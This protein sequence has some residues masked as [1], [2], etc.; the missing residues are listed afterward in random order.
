MEQEKPI[1]MFDQPAK[2]DSAGKIWQAARLA[3]EG[4]LFMVGRGE[5]IRWGTY[6]G[7]ELKETKEA[8]YQI[9][10]LEECEAP[11]LKPIDD[12]LYNDEYRLIEKANRCYGHDR[13]RFIGDEK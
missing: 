10:I 8:I 2:K 1:H 4:M 7:Y 12:S 13:C 5:N 3:K 11:E 9:A 6:V